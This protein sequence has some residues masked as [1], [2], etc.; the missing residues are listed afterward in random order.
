MR[1]WLRS[2]QRSLIICLGAL[3]IPLAMTAQMKSQ[4]PSGLWDGTIQGKAGEVNFGIELQQQ[5]K[6]IRAT[7]LNGTDRQPFSS[8]V[9]SGETLTLQLDYYDGTLTA[10]MSS[11]QRMQGEYSRQSSKGVVHIPLTLVPHRELAPGKPWTGA[12]LNGDWIMHPD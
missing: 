4:P 7:L 6:T 1:Q 12:T 2:G 3:A 11:P 9:W 8:A 5:G 10:H